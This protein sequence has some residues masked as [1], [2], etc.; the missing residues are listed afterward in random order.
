MNWKTLILA[1]CL[2]MVSPSLWAQDIK[3]TADA[4][5][6]QD[7]D[8]A[9]VLCRSI[10]SS[11][12]TDPKALVNLGLSLEGQGDTEKAIEHWLSLKGRGIHGLPTDTQLDLRIEGL[13]KSMVVTLVDAQKELARLTLQRKTLLEPLKAERAKA[14]HQLEQEDPGLGKLGAPR[15]EF[16]TT[17][18]YQE[19]TNEL[20]DL[21]ARKVQKKSSIDAQYDELSAAKAKAVDHRITALKA[22]SVLD[23]YPV[24]L[25]TYNPD[26]GTFVIRI[27]IAI[28]EYVQANLILDPLRAKELKLRKE[29]LKANVHATIN[30]G[31]DLPAQ[32]LDP[33]WGNLPLEGAVAR[34]TFEGHWQGLMIRPG[35]D[36]AAFTLDLKTVGPVVSGSSS[37]KEIKGMNVGFF[38][39]EM[40]IKGQINPGNTLDLRETSMSGSAAYSLKKLTLTLVDTDGGD[41]LSGTWSSPWGRGRIEV[42][43]W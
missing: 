12:P 39:A 36:E 29:H 16:E 4:L 11:M 8:Q 21:Q 34:R 31:S 6:T 13:K 17:A 25:R 32:I 40:V 33:V 3:T 9:E 23:T 24:D 41:T 10:L 42:T 26:Q 37:I 15:D 5:E 28:D 30:A 18:Q 1:I 14:L 20:K 22:Q 43:R 19:R 27:P 2:V 38:S 35:S 7:F